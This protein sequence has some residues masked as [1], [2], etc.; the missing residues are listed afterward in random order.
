[1]VT[2][3]PGTLTEAHELVAKLRPALSAPPGSWLEFRLRAARIYADVADVD[4]FHH[5][6]ASYWA[7]S[8][9]KKADAIRAELKKP[10]GEQ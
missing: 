7:A 6:E 9:R 5:H 1:M 2:G 8:E 4:R 3:P 10:G